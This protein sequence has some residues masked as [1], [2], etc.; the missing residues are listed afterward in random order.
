MAYDHSIWSAEMSEGRRQYVARVLRNCSGE[1]IHMT[2]LA[3]IIGTIAH[4]PVPDEMKAN[5]RIFHGTS[6]RRLLSGDIDALNSDMRYPFVIIS[7]NKGVRLGN[8]AEVEQFCQAEHKEAVK[9]LAKVAKIARKAGLD[10]QTVLVT[11]EEIKSF[12][13]GKNETA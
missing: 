4:E 3:S 6:Y 1:P 11:A 2:M 13:E 7:D 5:K 10:G 8:K 12:V 9:K